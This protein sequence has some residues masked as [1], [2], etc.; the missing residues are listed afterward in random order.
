M[1]VD[2]VKQIVPFYSLDVIISVGY[3]AKAQC[4]A[5]FKKWASSVLKK[6]PE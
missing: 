3:Q 1:R 4:R 6:D 5:I 2:G